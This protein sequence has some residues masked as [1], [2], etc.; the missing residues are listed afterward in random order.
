[1]SDVRRLGKMVRSILDGKRSPIE[2]GVETQSDEICDRKMVRC[3]EN[4][5]RYP[6]VSM[7]ETGVRNN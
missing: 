3:R 4:G 5:K 7:A 2:A 6:F 1:M